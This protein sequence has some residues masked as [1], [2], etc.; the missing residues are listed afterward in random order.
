[1][2]LRN[3]L[4]LLV[5]LA[6]IPALLLALWMNFRERREGAEKVRRDAVRVVQLIAARQ[7]GFV[8]A[9]REKLSGL[10]KIPAALSKETKGFDLFFEQWTK[11]F[12][13]YLDYGL[14]ETN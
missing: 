10:A 9:T 12:T 13:N 5:S 14:I 6:A 8:E 2:G 11:A 4:L 3:R 7:I 1:M